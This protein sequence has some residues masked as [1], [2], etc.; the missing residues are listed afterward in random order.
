MVAMS[1]D[2]VEVLQIMNESSLSRDLD[3][4]VGSACIEQYR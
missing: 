1:E 4:N 3:A 2:H